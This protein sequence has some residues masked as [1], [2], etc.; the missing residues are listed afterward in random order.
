MPLTKTNKIEVEMQNENRILTVYPA[1][2]YESCRTGSFGN[3]SYMFICQYNF[4]NEYTKG[5][6]V[7]VSKDSDQLES[8]DSDRYRKVFERHTGNVDLFP[9]NFEGWARRNNN[10]LVMS[11]LVDI[12]RPIIKCLDRI[13]FTG[14]RIMA[15]AKDNGQTVWHFQLFIKSPETKTVVYSDVNAPNVLKER[16]YRK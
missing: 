10:K 14:Y 5:V 2:P 12:L 8:I 4:P 16:R 11:F 7:L 1:E 3:A 9:G 13:D 15:T 6:D